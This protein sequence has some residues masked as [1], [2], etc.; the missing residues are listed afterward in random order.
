MPIPSPLCSSSRHHPRAALLIRLPA[1]L[2][3]AALLTASPAM[4]ATFARHVGQQDPLSQG[5]VQHAGDTLMA[6]VGFGP[7]APGGADIA[8]WFV[9]DAST[10]SGSRWRYEV[11][12]ASSAG[13][14]TGWTLRSKLRVTQPN[15]ALD[16]SVL[17]ELAD[18]NRRFLL[19]FGTTGTSLQI[20]L[21]G[22][23]SVTV[24][25][26]SPG[27]TAYH[28]IELAYSPTLGIAE[29]YVDGQRLLVNQVG[30]AAAGLDRLHFGSGQSGS[31]GRARYALV[32]LL[33]GP[34]ACSDGLD[35]DGD[36]FVD[37]AGGDPDCT[38]AL[39]PHEEA[40]FDSDFD[41][42][43]D[44]AE[45]VAG[46]DPLRPDSDGDGLRDAFEIA[47]GFDPNVAGEQS[48][49]PDGD[50]LDNAAE[51]AAGSHP[52]LTDSDGDGLSDLDEVTLHGSDPARADS[53]GD[54]LSDALEVGTTGTDPAR[55]DS[56][57]D[58][59]SD[60][61]EPGTA[62]TDPLDADSDD[63]GLNDGNELN[64]GTDPLDPDSDDDGLLDG[65]EVSSTQTDPLLADSDGDGLLDGF[66]SNAGFDPK[67]AGEQGLDP[68]GDGLTNLEEQAA[69]SDPRRADTDGDGL[70]DHAEVTTHGTDVRLA[71]TDADGL[72]DGYE[73]ANGLDPLRS[74]DADADPDV[75]GLTNLRERQ[76]KTDPQLADTD[77]D[78]AP[79]G[80]EVNIL[81]TDPLDPGSNGVAISTSSPL[82]FEAVDQPLFSSLQA[83]PWVIPIVG[84]SSVGSAGQIVEVDQPIPLWKAQAIWDQAIA[85]CTSQVIVRNEPPNSC[86]TT[87]ASN[88]TFGTLRISPTT[89][90]CITGVADIALRSLT[91]CTFVGIP[92][93]DSIAN[94]CD[95]PGG[96]D[97]FTI[98]EI[99]ALPDPVPNIPTSLNVGAAIGPRPT[100][101]PPPQGF[102]VGA[103]VTH[104]VT[105]NGQIDVT[106]D[107][108]DG[109]LVDLTYQT[110]AKL[111]SDR[112]SVAAGETFTLEALHDPTQTTSTLTS[113][114]PAASFI[115]GYTFDI[116]AQLDVHYASVDPAT[117]EQIDRNTSVLDE[118]LVETG[119]LVGFRTGL[120]E[121]LEMRFMNGVP[122]APEGYRD[123]LF[124]IPPL[125]AG[126]GIDFG[127]TYPTTCPTLLLEPTPPCLTLPDVPAS[128]DLAGIRFQIPDLESPAG[129][130]YDPG[131]LALGTSIL[132][133]P[134]RGFLEP[135]GALVNT[136]PGRYRP[137]T[138]F[139]NDTSLFEQLFADQTSLSSDVIRG[140]IDVDGLMALASSGTFLAGANF[141]DPSGLLGL[142]VDVLD[143]DAVF[144][145]H[146]EQTLTFSPNLVADVRFGAPVE[147]FDENLGQ[148]VPLAAGQAVT[149]AA[150]AE[151]G[152]VPQALL[153]LGLP[154]RLQVKQPAGGV[155]VSVDYSFRENRFDNETFPLWTIAWQNT[156]LQL[157][158]DG[159]I[160]DTMEEAGLPLTIAAFRSTYSATEPFEEARRGG[161]DP[162]VGLEGH[163]FAGGSFVVL[164]LAAD[165]D[166]DGLTDALENL[167]CSSSQDADSDDDGIPDG[168]EDANR[169]GLVDAGETHPCVA[170]SDGDGHPDGAERGL[171]SPTPDPDGAGPLLGTDL[172][173]FVPTSAPTLA[174]DP[175][176]PDS[177]DDGLLDGAEF[178]AY[179]T[180]PLLFDTDG[181]GFGDGAEIAA[182]SDPLD[183][184]SAPAPQVPALSTE[185][186]GLLVGLLIGLAF[187]LEGGRRAR[188]TR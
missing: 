115:A 127:F 147:I 149:I 63:D 114:W 65:T 36:G 40:D 70:D 37:F 7:V 183:P 125:P 180:N 62:G 141:S 94:G 17:L 76:L 87:G 10:A 186:T 53:D 74:D 46:S 135:D 82:R 171:L 39:D 28:L 128:V 164:D 165:A 139:T 113:E 58:G 2:L 21:S 81:G 142:S 174:S 38:S 153:D 105:V 146:F 20:A 162:F 154:T 170:D 11:A 41:G 155:Q 119:E 160:F 24:P 159:I 145:N 25:T 64:A 51:Q 68:D 47:N 156:Y 161:S 175:L 93:T 126:L 112:A 168:L 116:T 172:A 184:S 187:W 124:E 61:E 108:E 91:C 107:L 177:D 4:A 69:D 173:L 6:G 109:G 80:D 98:A 3:T 67:T 29:L 55:A 117:G 43:S 52:G 103:E 163:T 1:A 133:E 13:L 88:S 30:V 110:V 95:L 18:G 121:G 185:G 123:V 79:D 140:E 90:E 72:D 83:D 44:A 178:S 15:D 138:N 89:N 50:G 148:F 181:D 16:A 158:L 134:K 12:P 56:D 99:N 86:K 130:D 42:A 150:R 60:A 45:A 59:L 106:L 101:P 129:D 35:D 176:D 104:A 120:F 34:P 22:G 137:A 48:A 131:A 23:G 75:D 85:T 33:T 92:D 32:E 96:I 84:E 49:D 8:S 77:G 152:S 169:N 132:A 111:R 122:F 78:G 143:S 71:D 166:G 118:H 188:N 136:M 144:W 102:D 151:G 179:G 31:T 54:G 57:G 14:A 26:T 19:T 73:I 5:W 157:S 27:L 167:S 182:G 97:D 9:D 66:E 100:Q